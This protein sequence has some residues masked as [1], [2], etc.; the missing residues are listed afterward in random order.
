M[1]VPSYNYGLSLFT[2]H[3]LHLVVVVIIMLSI[4]TVLCILLMAVQ[5]TLFNRQ[6][7]PVYRSFQVSRRLCIILTFFLVTIVHHDD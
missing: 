7:D 5:L 3:L 4:S 6:L 1:K 2:L